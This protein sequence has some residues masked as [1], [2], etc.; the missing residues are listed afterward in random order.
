MPNR[1]KWK[2]DFVRSLLSTARIINLS[3]NPSDDFSRTFSYSKAHESSCHILILCCL[4]IEFISRWYCKDF[5]E[6]LLRTSTSHSMRWC[7][8]R[9]TS[10]SSEHLLRE[11]LW[12]WYNEH[13]ATRD[14]GLSPKLF[15]PPTTQAFH[16]VVRLI[17]MCSLNINRQWLCC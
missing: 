13:V 2:E 5:F 4:G 8:K 3:I 11:K 15:Q 1:P 16:T 17:T 6:N 12:F 14:V 7:K 9:S 10:I